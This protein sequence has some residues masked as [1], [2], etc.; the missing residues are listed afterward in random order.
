LGD[1]NVA[2]EAASGTPNRTNVT[3][4][5]KFFPCAVAGNYFPF[6]V[7]RQERNAPRGEQ[8][9]SNAAVLN[10]QYVQGWHFAVSK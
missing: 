4:R 9:I 2:Q 6:V 7:D 5:G 8:I 10:L 3:S 1:R